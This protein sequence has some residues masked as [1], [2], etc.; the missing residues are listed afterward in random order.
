MTKEMNIIMLIICKFSKRI[1]FIFDKNIFS[2]ENWV[3]IFLNKII[4]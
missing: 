2:A 3:E 1:I 4:D